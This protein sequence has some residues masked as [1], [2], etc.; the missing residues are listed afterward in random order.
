MKIGIVGTGSGAQAL[1]EGLLRADHEIRFGSPD[2]S[3]A[4]VPSRA[5]AVAQKEATDWT[6][7][8]ILAVPYRAMKGTLNAVGPAA[9]RGKI[10]IDATN[11]MGTS[12]DLIAQ[13]QTTPARSRS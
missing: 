10:V 8:V 4:K 5:R 11:A 3:N 2:S 13:A 6:D 7:L 12:G 1:A 9:F